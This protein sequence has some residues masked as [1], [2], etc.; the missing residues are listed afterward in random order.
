MGRGLAQ[1]HMYVL[2]SNLFK[3]FYQKK[4]KKKNLFELTIKSNERSYIWPG[5]SAKIIRAIY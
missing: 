3:L 5:M 1:E 4:N 2:F